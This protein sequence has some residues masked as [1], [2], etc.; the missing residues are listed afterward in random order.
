MSEPRRHWKFNGFVCTGRYWQTA[1]MLFTR[2]KSLVTCKVCVGL[3][4]VQGK[5][6]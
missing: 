1:T 3:L 6:P 2:R 4:R 5:L